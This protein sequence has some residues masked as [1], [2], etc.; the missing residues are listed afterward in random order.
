VILDAGK[1]K[2]YLYLDS[3]KFGPESGLKADS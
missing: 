2:Y 1:D 3:Q